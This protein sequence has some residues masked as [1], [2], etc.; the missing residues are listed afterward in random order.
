MSHKSSP[1]ELRII[2]GQWR[3]RKFPVI[4]QPGLRPTPDRVRET[5]FNWLQ[6][7]I[8]GARCLDLF[9]GTGALG[10]E[11]L[12]RGAAHVTFVDN[13]LAAT[14][15]IKQVL[16]RFG[17]DNANVLHSDVTRGLPAPALPYDIVFLDP[18]FGLNYIPLA[19]DLLNGAGWLAPQANIYIETESTLKDLALPESWHITREKITGQVCYRLVAVGV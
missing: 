19:C 3:G 16:T 15:Q 5:L 2:A 6:N 10:L 14:Q 11:A 17:A 12:S 9:A 18:P 13:N 8:I 1:G 4:D 7:K